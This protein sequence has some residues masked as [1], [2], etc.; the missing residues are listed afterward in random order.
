MAQ[1][2]APCS[3]TGKLIASSRDVQRPSR[4]LWPCGR[5]EASHGLLRPWET[6]RIT[7]KS[8]N[9][10]T[11][12]WLLAGTGMRGWWGRAPLCSA[13]VNTCNSGSRFRRKCKKKTVRGDGERGHGLARGHRAERFPLIEFPLMW[14]AGSLLKHPVP[15]SSHS[16]G[17]SLLR[18]VCSTCLGSVLHTSDKSY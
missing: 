18:P 3:G 12:G 11:M 17:I 8:L 9:T 15:Q 7:K 10:T 14:V 4:G 5:A 1:V 13:P 16:P 2:W 6:R